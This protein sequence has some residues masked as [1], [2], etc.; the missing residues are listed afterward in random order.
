[1]IDLLTWI[2]KKSL[3]NSELVDCGHP[4]GAVALAAA[5]VCNNAF[6]CPLAL[7]TDQWGRSSG[8]SKCS[9]PARKSAVVRFLVNLMEA[10]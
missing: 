10:S 4:K 5:G 2:M 9:I 3:E 8:P 7:L 1:M 6:F